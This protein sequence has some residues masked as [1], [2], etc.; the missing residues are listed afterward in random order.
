MTNLALALSQDGNRATALEWAR[1]AVAASPAYAH[2]HQILGKIALADGRNDEALA[3]FQQAM[4]FEP[5]NPN[6]FNL[7]LALL[8]LHRDAEARPL[9]D[10]CAA[11]PELA[12]RVRAILSAP[13]Q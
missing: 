11:D 2:G 9:L 12:P 8:A 7:A 3:A 5:S 4:A 10:A 6:R 1:R 13:R